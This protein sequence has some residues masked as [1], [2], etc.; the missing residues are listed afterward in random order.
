MS[1]I[2][3]FKKFNVNYN[4]HTSGESGHVYGEARQAQT[5]FPGTSI[6]RPAA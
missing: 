2:L 5:P 6:A 3:I 1:V 4:V